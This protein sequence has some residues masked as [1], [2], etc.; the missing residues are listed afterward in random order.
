MEDFAPFPKVPRL[1][2]D[3]VITEKIDGTNA[4]IWID[5]ALVVER[6]VGHVIDC[7]KVDGIDYVIRAGSRKRFI[8]PGKTNDNAGFAAWVLEHAYALIEG[9]GMGVHYGEWWGRGIQRGYDLEEKRFSLFNV[10]RWADFHNEP[11]CMP[12]ATYAPECCHVVP[13]LSGGSTPFSPVTIQSALH[14][15]SING[16][17][18]APGYAKPEGVVVYHTAAKQLF[19]MTLEDDDAGK[20]YGA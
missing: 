20:G 2:R 3:M 10:H 1:A 16:S 18:A 8:T 7:I 17:C 9:L 5:Q 4:S 13:V 19:K 12:T 15:L 14:N 6:G 11:D